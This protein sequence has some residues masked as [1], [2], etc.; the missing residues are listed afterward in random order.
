MRSSLKFEMSLSLPA[1]PSSSP[2]SPA[3][4]ESPSSPQHSPTSPSYSPSTLAEAK[5]QLKAA[6]LKIGQLELKNEQLELKN[7]QLELTTTLYHDEVQYYRVRLHTWF[8]AYLKQCMATAPMPQHLEVQ[9]LS[10]ENQDGLHQRPPHGHRE[11][12][13]G[14]TTTIDRLHEILDELAPT[15]A[16]E[17]KLDRFLGISETPVS[18][19][20]PTGYE[21]HHMNHY[22]PKYG[23][24]RNKSV[25]NNNRITFPRLDVTAI[26][27]DNVCPDC[28]KEFHATKTMLE[29]W[30]KVHSGARQSAHRFICYICTKQFDT[31]SHLTQHRATHYT[32]DEK[33]HVSNDKCSGEMDLENWRNFHNGA[34]IK[35]NCETC[36]KEYSSKGS[37]KEHIKFVHQVEEGKFSCER[38]GT[39]FNR[40]S[41]LKTHLKG[42]R[43]FFSW[44]KSYNYSCDKCGKQF[45]GNKNLAQ[46]MMTHYTENKKKHVCNVCGKRFATPSLL[47]FHIAHTHSDDRPFACEVSL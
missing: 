9:E 2:T 38:C 25:E 4:G 40:R 21:P 35:Y 12:E 19:T 5:V 46:H 31:K 45:Y 36:G 15:R 43:C 13:E 47:K 16:N 18:P 37:L 41:S 24:K 26:T 22:G 29:H 33:L 44:D 20:Q 17:R 28:R 23:L 27:F 1:S 7:E 14:A 32:E 3:Y 42:Q 30:R 6:M 8:P 39:Q 11:Q 34:G 10:G